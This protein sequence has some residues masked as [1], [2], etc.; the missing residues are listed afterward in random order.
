M[1]ELSISINIPTVILF[2]ITLLILGACLFFIGYLLG[3]QSSHGV[4]TGVEKGSIS[5]FK[6]QQD[7]M[8]KP[9]LMDDR[10]FV[11]DIKTEGLEKKYESLGDVK[12]SQENISE[13]INKLKNLKR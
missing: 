5:F 10:K 7:E 6:Q 8:P 2:S 12:E 13:S 4:S 11:T 1:H 9:I 3:K